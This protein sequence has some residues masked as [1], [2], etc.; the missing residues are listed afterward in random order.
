[1]PSTGIEPYQ[2]GHLKCL[3]AGRAAPARSERSAFHLRMVFIM[4]PPSLRNDGNG[5]SIL[6]LSILGCIF[7]IAQALSATVQLKNRA[8]EPG[9][10]VQGVRGVQ[11]SEG[12]GVSGPGRPAP[13]RNY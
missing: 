2:A 6:I 10:G 8:V 11:A 12:V 4:Q 1:M 3:P 7:C 9:G 5:G 13:D